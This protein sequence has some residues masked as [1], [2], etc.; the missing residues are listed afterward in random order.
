VVGDQPASV[1]TN[2]L[3]V[4]SLILGI[5]GLSAL[6]L[7]GAV[8]ALFLGYK[9]RRA[10]AITGERGEGMATAGIVLGWVGIGVAVVLLLVGVLLFIFLV[11]VR[12]ETS[13][14]AALAAGV[15]L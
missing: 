8:L 15:A 9:A 1:E 13:S 14:S 12:V 11:P 7:I 6:P 10:I 5:L 3:A 2:G 4:A